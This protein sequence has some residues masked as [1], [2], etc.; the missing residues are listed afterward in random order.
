MTDP[1]ATPSIAPS[2]RPV[3]KRGPRRF[4]ERQ[5]EQ[6]ARIIAAYVGG[7]GA[8]A[9]AKGEGV[10]E[11]RVT[12]VLRRAGVAMREAGHPRT[13]TH[14]PTYFDAITD[15]ARAYWLGFLMADGCV[16]D[17]NYLKLSLGV[18]DRGHLE[19][20][21]AALGSTHPITEHATKGGYKPG[22]IITC[23][24][25]RCDRLAAGLAR[26]GVVPRKSHTAVPPELPEAL[27][28]HF[29]RGMVDGDGYIS[30]SGHN[31]T[32]GL[33]GNEAVCTAFRAWVRRHI[34]TEA[35]VRRNHTAWKYD[36]GGYI[37][38][39]ELLRLLYD[40]ATI[41]LDRKRE[42]AR[43]ALVG[44]PLPVRRRKP[45]PAPLT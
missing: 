19:K 9:I 14:D 45:R 5:P 38:P 25:L 44:E 39:L 26:G 11:M 31:Y 1:T 3:T 10:S 28:R 24:G 20:L 27:Q 40:G 15:E 17:G 18:I 32:V 23:F 8:L 33:T 7:R 2:P 4:I 37:G 35:V 42:L 43:M 13:Y 16:T 21:R 34:Q 29:W 12:G 22:A 6:V 41:A 30:Q 36:L